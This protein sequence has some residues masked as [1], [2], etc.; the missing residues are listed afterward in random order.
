MVA[1]PA[2][3]MAW[4]SAL[5]GRA[6][7]MGSSGAIQRNRDGVPVWD[8]EPST[9]EE[10]TE[11]CLRYEPERRDTCVAQG[12]PASC[13]VQPNASSWGARLTGYPM[14]EEFEDS[15]RSFALEEDNPKF[16]KCRSYL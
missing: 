15:S 1:E 14:K 6:E 5:P 12:L 2:G 10:F 7:W 9:L 13:G 4:Y 3:S 11:A 8:G 16:R